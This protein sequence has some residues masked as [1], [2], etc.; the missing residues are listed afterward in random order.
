MEGALKNM[1]TCSTSPTVKEIQF[2]LSRDT[3]F[4]YQ[5]GKTEQFEQTINK[6]MGN[7]T[8]LYTYK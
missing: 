3:I 7:N 1:Q 5:A 6:S 4:N 8:F 2:K